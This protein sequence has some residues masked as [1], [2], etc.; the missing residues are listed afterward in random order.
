MKYLL[1]LLVVLAFAAAVAYAA[2]NTSNQQV[3]PWDDTAL[4]KYSPQ[5][6][7]TPDLDC[8]TFTWKVT[9]YRTDRDETPYTVI[10]AMIDCSEVNELYSADDFRT[11]QSWASVPVSGEKI[12][13]YSSGH[14]HLSKNSGPGGDFDD[15]VLQAYNFIM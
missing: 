11:E 5:G 13:D 7:F 8:K 12:D 2:C 14:L 10:R 4:P 15:I 3:G 9:F 1:T 6:G